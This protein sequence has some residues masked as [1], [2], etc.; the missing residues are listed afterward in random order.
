M[1]LPPG[2]KLDEQERPKDVRYVTAPAIK[3]GRVAVDARFGGNGVGDFVLSYVVGLGRSL[4]D[5]IGLRYVT[6]DSLDR[7]RL[8]E[9]YEKFGFVR[10]AAPAVSEDGDPSTEISMRFDLRD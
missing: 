8:I 1:I 5:Q 4:A 2:F 10:N 3:L 6:L 7:P 9:R